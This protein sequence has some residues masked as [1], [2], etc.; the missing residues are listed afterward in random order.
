MKDRRTGFRRKGQ[1]GE[2]EDFNTARKLVAAATKRKLVVPKAESLRDEIDPQPLA[3]LL[4]RVIVEENSF[5]R[6]NE[7][8]R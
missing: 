8:K 5:F 3:S 7:L 6:E 2:V 4:V 1:L